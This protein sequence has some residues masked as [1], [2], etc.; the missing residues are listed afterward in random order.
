[1]S[2]RGRRIHLTIHNTGAP[3]PSEH[4][5]HLFERFYRADAARDRTQG[6]YGLGLAIAKSITEA[7]RGKISVTSSAD[8]GTTFT[9]LFPRR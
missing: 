8:A 7:H 5:P 4:L 6:G 3:I 2:V 9:V 1:M